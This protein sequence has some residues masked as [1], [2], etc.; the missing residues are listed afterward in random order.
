MRSSQ[1]DETLWSTQDR[2]WL[3]WQLR[4]DGMSG[5]R[6]NNS[7]GQCGREVCTAFD[8]RTAPNKSIT[9]TDAHLNGAGK[10]RIAFRTTRFIFEGNQAAV[11]VA[12]ATPAVRRTKLPALRREQHCCS[13]PHLVIMHRPFH[14]FTAPRPLFDSM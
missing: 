9:S 14:E 4:P 10:Y 13:N 5:S 6:S 8:R 1:R 3:Y 12:H 11:F 7:A 2:T